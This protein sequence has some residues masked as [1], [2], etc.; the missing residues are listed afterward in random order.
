ML[1]ALKYK[2]NENDVFNM[3]VKEDEYSADNKEY[4]DDLIDGKE[5]KKHIELYSKQ[6]NIPEDVI[7][8][9]F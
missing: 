2:V 6:Y 1:L 3:L 4:R 7:L 9:V 5:L 8:R